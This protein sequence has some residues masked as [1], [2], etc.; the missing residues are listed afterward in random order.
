MKQ[1][2]FIRFLILYVT[3]AAIS[4]AVSAAVGGSFILRSL[5][6]MK[7]DALYGHVRQLADYFESLP[8]DEIRPGSVPDDDLVILADTEEAD[9]RY[10]GTDGTIYACALKAAEAADSDNH[11]V[12][13]DFDYTDFGPMYYEVSTFFD[14]YSEP[15]LSVMIPVLSGLTT[16]G[17]L[18]VSYPVSGLEETRDRLMQDVFKVVFINLAISFAVLIFALVYIIRPLNKITS[19][20]RDFAAGD[21]TQ[22]INVHTHDEMGYLSDS[23]NYM[24]DELEKSH[25]YHSQFLANVSH[26]FRSPL[27]SILGFTEAMR[28]GTIPPEEYDRYLGIISGEAKRL[29]K[30]TSGILML[31]DLNRSTISLSF[32]SFDINEVLRNTAAV[33]EGICRKKRIHIRLILSGE[34]LFVNADQ[35]KIEQVIYNLLDNA[36]K[37]SERNSEIRLETTVKYG[38]CY[39]SVS[40]DGCGIPVSEQPR[41]WD[42]FYKTDSSRGLDRTGTG[43]GLAI[44]K[45]IITAHGQNINVISTPGA[46]TTFTFTLEVSP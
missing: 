21:F 3:L 8:D 32:A 4:L 46:G 38:R 19:H 10:I 41:I 22:R 7:A 30:L 28:D 11:A 44:A 1:T 29:E 31:N 25:V 9:V 6:R 43:L 42:R 2:L 33:F 26:D 17:Y 23:L 14:L 24:A 5:T 39:L 15:Y 16:R 12:I 45:E 18:S 20:V 35:E 13:P 27:T 34:T 40:D 37:F 36:I